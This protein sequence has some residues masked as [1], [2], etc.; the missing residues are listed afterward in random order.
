MPLTVSNGVPT[1]SV[2]DGLTHLMVPSRLRSTMALRVCSAASR[3]S[4]RSSRMSWLMERS[5][6]VACCA[7][8][9]DTA[10]GARDG[11]GWSIAFT[12]RHR[13]PQRQHHNV[14]DR[15]Q[16]LR[17]APPKGEVPP[18]SS[19][20][21]RTGVGA[22][23]CTVV[24]VCVGGLDSGE[25]F[26]WQQSQNYK[27]RVVGYMTGGAATAWIALSRLTQQ[28]PAGA[29][30]AEKSST[31]ELPAWSAADEP[32]FLSESRNAN[33]R[34]GTN[35]TEGRRVTGHSE[36]CPSLRWEAD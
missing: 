5:I 29:R 6:G 13:R 3:S 30:P 18:D 7:R 32:S 23:Q 36:S 27:A 31:E 21:R 11:D 4:S 10:G 22:R 26:V 16:R 15:G 14:R 8:S 35:H 17:S 20:V 19:R 24:C 2:H 28:R 25:W 9:E 12:V 34:G 33:S 1:T